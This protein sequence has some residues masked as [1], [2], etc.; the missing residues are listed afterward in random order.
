MGGH[1]QG[2]AGVVVEPGEDLDVAAV[3]EP[4]VGEVGLP[5]FVGL[6]G[7]EPQVGGLGSF[8]RLGGDQSL[9]GQGSAHRGNRH[10]H[11]VMVGQVPGD[12]VRS[13]VEAGLA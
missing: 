6:L 5:G 12:G 13:G 2:I 3:A 10:G 8:G 9:A 1:G 7:A 4:V 11:T